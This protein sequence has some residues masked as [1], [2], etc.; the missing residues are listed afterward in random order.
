MTLAEKIREMNPDTIVALYN[1]YGCFLVAK[2]KFVFSLVTLEAW[3]STEI[4]V[5]ER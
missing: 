3:R 4:D 1:K 5:K 2:A